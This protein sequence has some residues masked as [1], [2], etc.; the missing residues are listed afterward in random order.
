MRTRRWR[1]T[2]APLTLAAALGTACNAFGPSTLPPARKDYAESIRISA[3][4]ELLSNIV[5]LRFAATPEMLD[6]SQVVTQYRSTVTGRA[7]AT[8]PYGENGAGF[9]FESEW[10][11]NPTITYSPIS[12]EEFAIRLLAPLQLYQ[13]FIL[14]GSGWD[15]PRLLASVVQKVNGLEN[16]R[17]SVELTEL[18]RPTSFTRFSEVVA[19]VA[20][21]EQSR[22][23]E[24]E[25]VRPD[26]HQ[27]AKPGRQKGGERRL[28]LE[29]LRYELV[30]SPADADSQFAKASGRLKELLGLDPDVEVVPIRLGRYERAG[31][32]RELV[33]ETRSM[34][35]AMLYFAS[36]IKLPEPASRLYPNTLTELA[37]LNEPETSLYPGR[38][39]EIQVST[40]RPETPYANSEIH[41]MWFWI[42]RADARSKATFTLLQYLTRLQQAR[43]SDRDSELLLTIPTD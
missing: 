1:G 8:F 34:H 12:G 30:F 26:K 16:L 31:K 40:E 39:L 9:G 6:V 28:R 38:L 22:G 36:G 2:F 11:E 5:R 27:A 24:I 32:G 41:G 17:L 29:A 21:L 13:V 3:N 42:D 43:G 20:Q 33:V 19:L 15:L 10:R 14:S 7:G 35:S 23:L 4:N 37:A 18:P 25:M